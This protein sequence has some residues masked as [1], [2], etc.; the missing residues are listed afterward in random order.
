M[1][2][3]PAKNS[4]TQRLCVINS[5]YNLQ[6]GYNYEVY[7]RMECGAPSFYLQAEGRSAV[8]S[9]TIC[10]RSDLTARSAV[11]FLSTFLKQEGFLRSQQK[12]TPS[13]LLLSARSAFLQCAA[14]SFSELANDLAAERSKDLF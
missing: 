11:L 5:S 2:A 10:K 13:L 4:A 3:L 6:L 9:R 7:F 12:I 1:P 8:S 14:W